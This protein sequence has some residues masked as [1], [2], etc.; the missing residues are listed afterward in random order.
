[1]ALEGSILLSSH[2]RAQGVDPVGKRTGGAGY[3]E[4]AVAA[5][6]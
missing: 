1:M 6:S 3:V 4:R 5:L 2:D